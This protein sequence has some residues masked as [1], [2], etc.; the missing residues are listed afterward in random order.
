MDNQCSVPN[1]NRETAYYVSAEYRVPLC[2]YHTAKF[3][4]AYGRAM[5]RAF[6]GGCLLGCHLCVNAQNIIDF[7][8]GAK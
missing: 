7:A 6:G 2:E 8:K 1:C 5:R 4:S 3:K